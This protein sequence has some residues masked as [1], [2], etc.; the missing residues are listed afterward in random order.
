MFGRPEDVAQFLI[1]GPQEYK[2]LLGGA[3]GRRTLRLEHGGIGIGR[4]FH[5]LPEQV[6]IDTGI[7]QIGHG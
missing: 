2:A 1:Q 4:C 3:P 5:P 6:L 7:L